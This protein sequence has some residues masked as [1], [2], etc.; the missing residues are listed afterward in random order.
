MNR[1][2]ILFAAFVIVSMLAA[3]SGGAAQN[4][5]EVDA[6]EP[7]VEVVQTPEL[8]GDPE[9]G[10]KIYDDFNYSRCNYCHSLD[11]SEFRGGPTLLGISERAGTR[12]A[13]LSAAEYLRQSILDPSAYIV[14]GHT[15]EMAPYELVERPAGEAYK[16][17]FTFTEEEVN[18]LVAFL[19]TQ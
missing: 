13:E 3:C 10:K 1:F 2:I 8:V 12:V 15:K 17:P 16:E 4:L 9:N 5:V 11:G 6:T 18:D 7:P 14:E 19:L